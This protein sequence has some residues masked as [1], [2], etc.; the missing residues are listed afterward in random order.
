MANADKFN[1]IALSVIGAIPE[2]Q[3]LKVDSANTVQLAQAN[4]EEI[5]VPPWVR[6]PTPPPDPNPP[7]P[8]DDDFHELRKN[9][10]YARPRILDYKSINPAI[11]TPDI[12][13]HF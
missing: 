6:P 2:L 10:R 11:R 5:D 4:L 13:R 1:T 9:L 8:I 3:R 12:G 7:P